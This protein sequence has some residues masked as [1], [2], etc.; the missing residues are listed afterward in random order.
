MDDRRFDALTKRIGITSRRSFLGGLAG[1]AGVLVG[2]HLATNETEAARRGYS[3]PPIPTPAPNGH[4]WVHHGCLDG[5][6][7]YS[8]SYEEGE[9]VVFD[10]FIIM[11]LNSGQC[12]YSTRQQCCTWAVEMNSCDMDR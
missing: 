6:G 7:C 1:I 11:D 8:C 9:F 4:I 2:G 3:G 10:T 5:C 12:P